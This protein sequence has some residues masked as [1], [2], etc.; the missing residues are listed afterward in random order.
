MLDGALCWMER[1]A[2][3]S[4]ILVR[5]NRAGPHNVPIPNQKAKETQGQ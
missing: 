4:V 2:G 1:Y 5:V 3:W